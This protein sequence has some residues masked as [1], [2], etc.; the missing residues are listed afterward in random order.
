MN[1]KIQFASIILAALAFGATPSAYAA[2][3]WFNNTKVDF[4]Y[5]RDTGELRI[6]TVPK[7][8]DADG[9]NFGCTQGTLIL[10]T[11]DDLEDDDAVGRF[12]LGRMWRNALDA[13]LTGAKVDMYIDEVSSG[14]SVACYVRRFQIY[15]TN[16]PPTNPP[17][18]NPPPS[19]QY[20][21]AFA[22]SSEDVQGSP[23]EW[24]LS[25]NHPSRA[26][27]DRVALELCRD[28][29]RQGDSCSIETRFGNDE[30][31]VLYAG[32]NYYYI[33]YGADSRAN[34]SQLKRDTLQDCRAEASNCRLEHEVCNSGTSTGIAPHASSANTTARR[35]AHE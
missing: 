26:E 7:P 6:R 10:G 32:D 20:Y 15:A 34:L 35:K 13:F 31:F 4:L 1:R 14:T 11:S 27:A 19:S 22:L 12:A 25:T 21:G 8:Q 24:G 23:W 9:Q 28:R 29:I 3:G 18:T 16:T 33:S 30:C 2:D 17:P 5:A